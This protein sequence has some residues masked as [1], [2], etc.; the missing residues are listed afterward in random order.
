MP[1]VGCI[2]PGRDILHVAD[3][4]TKVISVF[5]ASSAVASGGLEPLLKEFVSS[6][7][8]LELVVVV[9][10]CQDDTDVTAVCS[11]AR[12]FAKEVR[13]VPSLMAR[14]MAVFSEL[15][16]T[17]KIAFHQ[18]TTFGMVTCATAMECVLLHRSIRGDGRFKVVEDFS[19]KPGAVFDPDYF[20][21]RPSKI[22]AVTFGASGDSDDPALTDKVPLETVRF[23]DM[24]RMMF[25]GGI[26]KALQI[27]GD[28][29]VPG[30]VDFVN[31]M[32]VHF[33]TGAM[34][35][36]ERTVIPTVFEWE[37][38]VSGTIQIRSAPQVA[39]ASNS[40]RSRVLFTLP[41]VPE[42]TQIKVE[43]DQ[44]GNLIC[45]D[46]IYGTC[47]E[48]PPSP[49]RSLTPPTPEPE[50]QFDPV[51]A[52][53]FLSEEFIVQAADGTIELQSVPGL[54]D[55][56][57]GTPLTLNSIY[58]R[59]STLFTH[60]PSTVSTPRVFVL[61]H[62]GTVPAAWIKAAVD[63]A[64]LHLHPE[65]SVYVTSDMLAYVNYA[66]ICRRTSKKVEDTPEHVFLALVQGCECRCIFIDFDEAE[67]WKIRDTFKV[68]FTTTDDFAVMLE[69]ALSKG[70][71][72]STRLL[73]TDV[74]TVSLQKA[75]ASLDI[76]ILR[77]E[78]FEK[79]RAEGL[80]SFANA[81][82]DPDVCV[83]RRVA[84]FEPKVKFVPDVGVEKE[85][86]GGRSVA[87]GKIFPFWSDVEV[88]SSLEGFKIIQQLSTFTSHEYV[89]F[90]TTA[91]PKPL[92]SFRITFRKACFD[93]PLIN[94]EPAITE[95]EY[96]LPFPHFVVVQPARGQLASRSASV[97]PSSSSS[98][99]NT[100]PRPTPLSL[101]FRG[102]SSRKSRRGRRA[103]PPGTSSGPIPLRAVNPS[104][105]IP[106]STPS[107][108]A[109]RINPNLGESQLREMQ[110]CNVDFVVIFDDNTSSAQVQLV[111]CNGFEVLTFE[112]GQ[113][114][115]PFYVSFAYGTPRFG[116]DAMAD[117]VWYR[118][119]V[120]QDVI[121]ILG[122]DVHEIAPKRTWDFGIVP[123]SSRNRSAMIAV[124]SDLGHLV[125]DPARVTALF[126]TEIQ[127]LIRRATGRNMRSVFLKL[128]KYPPKVIPA[129]KEACQLAPLDYK[130]S[131]TVSTR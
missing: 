39:F 18:C 81:I 5:A 28:A 32:V 50:P 70:H 116:Y 75:A 65:T 35:T 11:M 122:R 131:N 25:R 119:R 8:P 23:D 102:R 108:A 82:S 86:F 13:L 96:S 16:Q 125:L 67:G 128:P 60:F 61:S 7:E 115:L 126:L 52:H 64:N 127:S 85:L 47:S 10:T 26:V 29:S 21:D 19:R 92:S 15:R 101:F 83:S 30:V 123:R 53:A 130:G 97:T 59:C 41:D 6:N 44:F 43:V 37:A 89:L 31:A 111:K 34:K 95:S 105:P 3:T 9:D 33:E 114:W 14:V 74:A 58:E 79:A 40:C 120:V 4:D 17:R 49:P 63:M 42:H 93:A 54:T 117:Q 76:R 56:S 90:S 109:T 69:D 100:P 91:V 129:F 110:R 68:T 2:L 55:V 121:Q 51:V 1:F 80:V 113:E 20:M 22:A 98:S 112:D 36:L 124:Q 88:S 72:A 48:A 118:N 38:S 77:I 46:Q 94:L 84:D 62:D 107:A 106:P 57:N 87:V 99:V 45:A 27:L 78:S 71:E 24:D 12:R 66:L 73:M 103:A 104:R